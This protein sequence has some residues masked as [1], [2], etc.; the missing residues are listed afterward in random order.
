MESH[1]DEGSGVALCF[2]V[3]FSFRRW[4]K[5][6]ALSRNLTMTEFLVKAAET[7]AASAAAEPGHQLGAGK[8]FAT[9]TGKGGC[10]YCA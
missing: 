9:A 3:P 4:F 2:K 7:Y 10:R 5:L 8:Y 6:Q 1:P